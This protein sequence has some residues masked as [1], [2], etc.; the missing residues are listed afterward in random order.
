MAE[1]LKSRQE[2]LNESKDLRARLEEAEE[3][4]RAIRDG[5]VDALIV[6]QSEKTRT[7]LLKGADYP[8]QA[9]VNSMGE[10]AVTLI[11]DGTIFFC[12]SRFAEIV[13]TPLKRLIGTPFKDLVSSEDQGRLAAIYEQSGLD[14]AR[15][16]FR[17]QTAQGKFVSVQ[18]SAHLLETD[19]V[20]GITI[21]VT[22]LT[23]RKRVEQAQWEAEQKLDKM[24]QSLV[25]GMVV[26][27]LSGKITYANPSAERILEI[28][29]EKISGI[30]YS[31][32]EWKQ[33]D[34]NGKSYPLD[35][36]PLAI[37]LR[38][39]R[40]VNAL[41]HGIIAPNGEVKWLS[42]N[43]SPL[44]DDNNQIFGA[45]ASFRDITEQKKGEEALRTS[46][47]RY[48]SLFEN[49]REGFAYC[50]MLYENNLP[51]DFIYIDVNS[52]FEQ[53][54]GLKN[55]V[56]KKVSE[57]VP[58]I[59][60]TNPDLFEFYGRVASTGKP[61]RFNTY[62][63]QL[64]MWFSIAVYSPETGY[65]IAVFDNITE[66][67][68]AE[69]TL[70]DSEMRY[71]RLFEAAH[72][73]V[74][75]LDANSGA[76][77][78]VN[79]Y[80]VTMLGYSYEE[81]LGKKLWE[82]GAFTDIVANQLAFQELRENDFIRYED[83]PLR[84]K[85]GQLKNVEFVSNV[86]L[87]DHKK[88]IQCNIRDITERK[89]AEEEIQ[90]RTQELKMLYELSRSL[91]DAKNLDQVLDIV[92]QNAVENVH[93]TFSKI[94]LLE[95]DNLVMRAAHP[96]RDLDYDLFVGD[97][98]P[99]SDLPYCRRILEGHKTV[100]LNSSDLKAGS[101]EHETLLLNHV[102]SICLTPLRVGKT[103]SNSGHIQG[104]LILGE[105]RDEDREP[106]TPQKL[107]LIENIGNQAAS[108]IRRMLLRQETDRRLQ[109]LASLSE[110]D[111]AITA[112]VDLNISLMI[113]LAQ[114]I[115]QLGVDA[116]S[117]LILNS[118]T[119]TLEYFCGQGFRTKAIEHS[120]L[121][122]GEG[123]AGRA[124]LERVIVHVPNLQAPNNPLVTPNLVDEN[125]V[126][127]YGVPLIAKGQVKGVLEIFNHTLFKPDDEWL[128]FL[129]TLAEQAAIAVDNA[130]LF[131][132]L[133]RSNVELKLAYNDTIEGWSRALD[134]RDKET[135]GHTLR[136]ADKTLIL[137]RSFGLSE[138]ELAYIR[139]GGLLHDI[140]KMGVPDGIL[141][142]PGPL[143]DEEWV[144]MKK[145]PSMAYKML[146]PIRYLRHALDIPYCHHEKW[147]GTGYPRGL[148]GEQIP[149]AAR[150]FAVVD[151]WDA[152]TSDRPYRKAWSEEKTIEHIKSGSGTHFDP[153]VVQ[154]FLLDMDKK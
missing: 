98:K 63:E 22:D 143:T 20:K 149:L 81:F 3:T 99:I 43:A 114:V 80:L 122:L 135:E 102:R 21:V 82:I 11:P 96:I 100:V 104:L 111:R 119:Q 50:K 150:I 31:S 17:I 127:Y 124:A 48:R 77:F 118:G 51:R 73:G 70:R 61:E 46:E 10:G 26:V 126:E 153:Q 136:V 4:I 138:D 130:M 69:E 90:S 27:D 2:L 148:K 115:K 74:L 47:K 5:E 101:E 58:G 85:D 140:G 132:S 105:A 52:N 92:N 86:Y 6:A 33:I 94:G 154:T 141:L 7:F 123:H 129:K 42:V 75:L 134:L 62:I 72:D 68:Q 112:N 13:Q 30:Y 106:I 12:N 40:E 53:L 87:V 151:V 152:L 71:R 16:E 133:T 76:I 32:R 93:M 108:A 103:G 147:D 116:A 18:L 35:Q 29:K 38:E 34:A 23:D 55:V 83:L 36:L 45:I 19:D 41:E 120:R 95:G 67:K 64:G 9:M 8:Y 44:L 78:D 24:L 39:Q 79:P 59:Q 128:G 137:A 84:S 91:A 25:D 144:V 113:V 131:D 146:S 57:V 14:V 37:A 109:H 110:I 145:H 97:S 56:G 15:G 142:K 121:R 1:K 117:V 125:F 89:R 88:V 60:S 49:M 139:W 28:H 65:F 54:T 66:R 107:S